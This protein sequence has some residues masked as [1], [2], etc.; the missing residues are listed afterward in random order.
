MSNDLKLVD[1]PVFP[2]SVKNV[3]APNGVLVC[4]LEVLEDGY[5]YANFSDVNRGVIASWGLNRIAAL[6]D[7]LNK[8]WNDQITDYFNSQEQK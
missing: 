7:Q 1:H 2:H 4:Q 8:P 3:V 6:L 5:W